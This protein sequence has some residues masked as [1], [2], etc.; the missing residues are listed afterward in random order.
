MLIILFPL[1]TAILIIYSNRFGAVYDDGYG[2]N[3]MLTLGCTIL[4]SSLL[5]SSIE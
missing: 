5:M 1:T 2:I 4:S 3:C